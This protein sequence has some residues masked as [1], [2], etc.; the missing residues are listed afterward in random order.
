MNQFKKPDLNAPRFRPRVM[1]I[2]NKDLFDR[3]R[4]KFPKY[5]N[6]SDGQLKEIIRTFHGNIQ[7]GVTEKREGIELMNSMGIIFIGSC[8][9]SAKK[10]FDYTKSGHYNTPVTYK[11]WDTDGYI[12]KIF[13]TN[14]AVKYKIRNREVW[15]F[16]A[17]KEFRHNV[18]LAY[19]QDYRRYM[20]VNNY[21]RI[22]NIFRQK[23]DE[24]IKFRSNTALGDY[25]EFDV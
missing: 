10:N 17:S 12:G 1:N 2:L 3:F 4:A 6:V 5:A 20:F 25:N 9:S 8:K 21:L 16:E 19:R 15:E 22:S 24:A 23:K 11:N 14:Y 18:S 7:K 13:Y